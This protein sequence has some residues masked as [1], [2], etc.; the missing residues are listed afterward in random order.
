MQPKPYI[1]EQTG[2][3]FYN[4]EQ[5]TQIVQGVSQGT[6]WNWAKKGVTSFGLE[7]D[8]REEPLIHDPR[9]YRH[10]ARTH[11]ETRMLIPEQKVLAL[12]EILQSVGRDRPSHAVTDCERDALRV[13]TRK[14]R[15]QLA[16]LQHD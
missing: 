7:L 4:V 12:R 13:A 1:D 9:G 14:H 2:Q 16:T 15:S 5:A 10:N 8:V 3:R 6:M 11:K